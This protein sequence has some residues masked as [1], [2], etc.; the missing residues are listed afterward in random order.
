[1]VS[2]PALAQPRPAPEDV[3]INWHRMALELVRHTPTQ[4]PPVAARAFA[5]VGITAYEA[6]ASGSENLQSLAGQLNDLTALP[7]RE[8]GAVYDE[9]VVQNA[10]LA[11][12]IRE[13]FGNTGPTGQRAMQAMNDNFARLAE[14]GVPEGVVA[15]S[16]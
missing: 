5:Y 12:A 10:A 7:A 1:V 15:R 16:R 3:V 11:F 9:A 4:S 6:A 14:A 2:G 13:F 8:A